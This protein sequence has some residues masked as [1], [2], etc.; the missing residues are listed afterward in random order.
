MQVA[1]LTIQAPGVRAIESEQLLVEERACERNSRPIPF[2]ELL[3]ETQQIRCELASPREVH[4]GDPRLVPANP[5][6]Q[7]RFGRAVPRLR[8][9]TWQLGGQEPSK[10][11]LD[12]IGDGHTQRLPEAEQGRRIRDCGGPSGCWGAPEDHEVRADERSD[13]PE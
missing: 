3:L 1:A 9:G 10:V 6:T 13:D 11:R 4:V 12:Q 2:D 7:L 8:R 5:L